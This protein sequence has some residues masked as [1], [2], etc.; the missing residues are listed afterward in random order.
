MEIALSTCTFKDW[1]G[2]IQK[3]VEQA[4][5][6]DEKARKFLADY[7]L[8]KPT[9]NVN[10]R[11]EGDNRLII[12][13]SPA[14]SPVVACTR[15]WLTLTMLTLGVGMTEPRRNTVRMNRVNRIFL[16]R[17]GVFSAL[18]NADSI[19]FHLPHS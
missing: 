16:R 18:A 17:S 5:A 14:E 15:H 10:M 3:A 1:K 11:S 2:I 13:Y 4:L 12:E 6:G 19:R 8:G 9:Q 7:L